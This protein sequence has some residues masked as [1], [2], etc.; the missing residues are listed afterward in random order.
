MTRS[1]S[2]K[3]AA[4]AVIAAMAMSAAQSAAFAAEP[5]IAARAA[6]LLEVTTG[7]ALYSKNEDAREYPASMTKIL[8]AFTALDY[9]EPGEFIVLGDEILKAPAGSSLAYHSV[10][11]TIL[12]ENLIRGLMIKSGNESGCA[13]AYHAA[14]KITGRDDLEYEE[15]ERIF[16]EKM[17]EKA[18][19]LGAVD[20]HFTNPHGFHD[21]NHYTTA[22]DMAKLAVE[23]M[24]NP[25][26]AEIV[27]EM[28]FT[29][30]G[31]GEN[32]PEGAKTQDYTWESHNELIMGGENGYPPANGIKTGFTDEASDCLTASAKKNGINLISVVFYSPKP[33]V[34]NDTKALMEYG[35]N[36]FAFRTI[37]S[38]GDVM[39][40]AFILKPRLGEKEKIDVLFDSEFTK[41]LSEEE[42]SRIEIEI[43]Y[44]ESV[45]AAQSEIP[46]T[47]P[48][49]SVWLATPIEKGQVLGKAAYKMDGEEI[50]SGSLIASEGAQPRTFGSDMQYYW[51]K[52]KELSLTSAAI[53]YWAAGGAAFIAIV[54]II[55][56]F[57]GRIRRNRGGYRGSY[58]RNYRRSYRMR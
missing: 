43:S 4:A 20:T 49:G 46:E 15:A 52:F 18:K 57:A 55:A 11:E 42:A 48:Q 14:R 51:N 25:L 27:G 30:N 24:K 38:M 16:C 3:A 32:P 22:K 40:E 19:E 23:F 28:S 9:F 5:E 34:W 7:K 58:R 41:Y 50:F 33:G 8:T 47:A 54:V 35:F 2:L 6:I 29:G 53:R 56:I 17:N 36:T 21:D 10:G 13:V 45:L 12:F 44:D 26:L 37:Q 39:D 1:Y 31:G